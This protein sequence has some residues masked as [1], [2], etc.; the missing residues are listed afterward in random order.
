MLTCYFDEAGGIDHGFI[1]VAGYIASV[2]QWEHFEADWKLFLIS[3]KIPYFHMA[4]LS[5]F[6]GPYAKWADCPN[7]RARFLIDAAAIIQS[8]VQRGFACFVPYEDFK[9]ADC[10]YEL[11]EGLNS[12]YALAGMLCVANAIMWVRRAKNPPVNLEYIFEDGGPDKEGLLK[13]MSKSKLSAPIFKPSRDI[14]D[15]KMGL[16]PGVVQLQAADYLAYEIRKYVH[17]HPNRPARASLAALTGVEVDRRFL[18]YERLIKVCEDLKFKRRQLPSVVCLSH[19]ANAKGK[20][21]Q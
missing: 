7:F 1:V 16:R 20:A 21:A 6:K 18:S 12:P 19:D 15:R 8:R 9:R 2:E 14:R 11:R 4:K 13:A 10:D 3:Y 5:Q 17:D